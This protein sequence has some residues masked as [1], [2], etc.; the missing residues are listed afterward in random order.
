MLLCIVS[1][2]YLHVSRESSRIFFRENVPPDF[3]YVWIR[4]IRG[5]KQKMGAGPNPH[6]HYQLSIINYSFMMMSSIAF[7]ESAIRVPGPKMAAT[8]QSYRNW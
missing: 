7:A 6:S 5:D 3:L 4:V 8:P 2:F 1:I